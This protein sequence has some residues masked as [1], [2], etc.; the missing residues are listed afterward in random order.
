MLQNALSIISNDSFKAHTH[1]PIF[2]GFVAESV[3]ESAD[4]ITES[5]DYNIDSIIVGRLPLSNMFNILIPLEL[6]NSKLA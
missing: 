1:R 4:S 6:A 5:A 2:R 3:V